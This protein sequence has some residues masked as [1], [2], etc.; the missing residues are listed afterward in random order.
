[1]EIALYFILAFV[2]ILVIAFLAVIGM[3]IVE[4][5]MYNER[6]VSQSSISFDEWVNN[7]L[8]K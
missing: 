7:N 6:P 1:M 4:Y 3:L 8:N 5:I 2:F